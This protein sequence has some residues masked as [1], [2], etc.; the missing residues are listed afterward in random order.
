M[1]VLVLLL[2]PRS[3]TKFFP[4]L[5]QPNGY[6]VLTRAAATV[7]Q[8]NDYA[9]ALSTEQLAEL[10]TKNQKAF[11][12]LREALQMQCAVPVQMSENWFAVHSPELMVLKAAA[13]AW[14]A[15]A[16]LQL[17]RGD[18]NETVLT[19]LDLMRFSEAIGRGGVLIDFLVAAACEGVAMQRITN[20]VGSL[21]ATHCKQLAT[22]L[23]AFDERRDSFDE[24]QKREKEWIRRT[25]GAV[26]SILMTVQE[27]WLNPSGGLGLPASTQATTYD[28]RARVVRSA[29][30]DAAARA[31]RL[32]RGKSPSEV[33]DLI[34]AYLLRAP[35]DPATGQPLKLP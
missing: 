21:D 35:I 17:R 14:G 7:Q 29:L 5:P 12:L 16:E 22:F 31:Y 15:E 18:T 9:R 28:S 24:I 32:E 34:P 8:P 2:W 10:R 6:D 26:K 23:Q 4:P 11:A 20:L 19:C 13:M 27:R 33:S 30:L 3:Q 25:H 1:V